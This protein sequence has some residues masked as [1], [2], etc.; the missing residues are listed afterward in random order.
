MPSPTAVPLQIKVNGYLHDVSASPDTP[1]LY[2]IRNDLGLVSAKYGCGLGRCG[3]CVVHLDGVAV[4]SCM[5]PVGEVVGRE[6]TTLEGLGSP[7]ALHSLQQA[8]LDEQAA[9]CGYCTS[10][11]VMTAAALLKRNPHPSDTEIREELRGTLC[12]CGAHDR[13]LKAIH[14]S[15][16][17]EGAHRRK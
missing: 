4:V 2:V 9:Q 11:I 6:V 15:I 10:G 3:A 7:E 5:I 16:D 8:F 12:R 17:R 14:R 13:V 1:L